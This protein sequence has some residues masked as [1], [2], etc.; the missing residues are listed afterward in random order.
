MSRSSPWKATF[1]ASRSSPSFA[2]AISASTRAF[3][4]R[5]A[6]LIRSLRT[7]SHELK[8]AGDAVTAMCDR[9]R[10]LICARAAREWDRLADYSTSPGGDPL[11]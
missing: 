7:S 11:G 6:S 5:L 1:M 8:S 2:A 3:R 4:P 9:S 10:T